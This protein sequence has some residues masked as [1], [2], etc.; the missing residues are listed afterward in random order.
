[1]TR[2]RLALAVAAFAAAAAA[3]PA[4]AQE[5]GY[6][7]GAL[8]QSKL[9]E[10]CSPGL[11]SCKDT[12]TAWKLFG[13]YRFRYVGGEL[14]YVDWGTVDASLGANTASASQNGYGIAVVGRLPL[15]PQFSV[16]GKFGFVHI[17]QETTSAAGTRK[18]DDTGQHYGLGAG[19]SLTPNWSVR[20][21][22]ENTG[23]LKVRMWSIGAEYRF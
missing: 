13:G 5:G 11:T 23:E 7:G 3:A 10:W 1:M 4:V 6:V 15:G 22:W 2:G 18:R 12:D 14:F 20:A 9:K 16:F 21:E 8:G 17:E 19:Y